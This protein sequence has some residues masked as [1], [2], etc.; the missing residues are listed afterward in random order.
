MYYGGIMGVIHDA[1]FLETKHEIWCCGE[2]IIAADFRD[3]ASSVS[4][5]VDS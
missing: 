5:S 2:I 4:R 3:Q 1:F